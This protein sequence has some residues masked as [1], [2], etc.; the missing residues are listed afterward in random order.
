M[1]LGTPAASRL[2]S[3]LD[4][5]VS[6]PL[7]IRRGWAVFAGLASLVVLAGCTTALTSKAQPR[8]TTST[9]AASG[10]PTTANPTVPTGTVCLPYKA[11]NEQLG[12]TQPPPSASPP[13]C[14]TAVE[15]CTG[16]PAAIP[17]IV[18]FPPS[19]TTLPPIGY[20]PP[21]VTTPTE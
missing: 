1:G 21:P 12:C 10:V 5:E 7:C 2:G 9:I 8:A 19:T 15:D 14:Y 3:S 16:L 18:G 11:L 4:P 6:H 13:P 17:V 20:V